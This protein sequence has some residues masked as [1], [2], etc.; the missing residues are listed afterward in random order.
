VSGEAKDFLRR[1]LAYRQE[2]RWDVLS[3]AADPYLNL[4][5]G[6]REPRDGAGGSGAV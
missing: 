3:A 6:A 2:E 4:K 1:C 5:R